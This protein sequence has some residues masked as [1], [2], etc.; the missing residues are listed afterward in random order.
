VLNLFQSSVAE[1]ILSRIPQAGAIAFKIVNDSPLVLLVRAKKTPGE[2][3]F[4]KGHVEAG[5]TAEAAAA[6]ELEEEAGVKGES[7][8]LI[9]SLDFESGDEIVT[10]AYY[11]F[12]F[13]SDVPRTDKRE[14]RWCQYQ[15]ALALLSHRDA[16]EMLQKAWP[17]IESHNSRL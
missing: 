15:E 6:R 2:W 8:G 16:A 17:V 14:L 11:L 1:A 3:I 7:V 4:P 10:V 9:G 13:L 12:R 5:E